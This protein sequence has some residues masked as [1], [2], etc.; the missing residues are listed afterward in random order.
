MPP[1][2]LRWYFLNGSEYHQ[3]FIGTIIRVLVQQ[4]CAKSGIKILST[5]LRS[6]VSHQR[7]VSQKKKSGRKEA[8]SPSNLFSSVLAILIAFR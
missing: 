1:A 6:E 5:P 2:P 7:Y 4:L 8:E 3:K